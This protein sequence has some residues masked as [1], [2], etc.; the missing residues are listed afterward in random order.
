MIG[1]S[2]EDAAVDV[3]EDPDRWLELGPLESRGHWQDM[4]DF[5]ARQTN[6]DLRRRLESAVEEKGAFRRFRDV[7]HE[8]DLVT[9]WHPFSDD[10]QMGRARAFLSAAG[11]RAMPAS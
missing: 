7:V 5:A 8:E 1:L 6:S 3:E 10:R 2:E 11:I 4:A 9:Q